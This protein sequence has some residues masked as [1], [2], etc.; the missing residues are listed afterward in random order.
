MLE[1]IRIDP[2]PMNAARRGRDRTKPRRQ[3]WDSVRDGVMLR[4]V[5]AKFAQHPDLR[6]ILC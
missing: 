3:D 4:V 6:V 2:R 1:A 5:R